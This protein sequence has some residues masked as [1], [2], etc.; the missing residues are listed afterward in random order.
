LTFGSESKT[1]SIIDILSRPTL[2]GANR[3][4]ST[5]RAINTSPTTDDTQSRFKFPF[6]I[7]NTNLNIQN[8]LSGYTHFRANVG[9]KIV[10]NAQPFSQG[11][12]WIYFA[13][14]ETSSMTQTAANNL[15]CKTSYP[16]VELDVATGQP[17]EF[18]IPYC[19]P[20]PFF[21][22]TYGRGTMGD[23]YITVLA[24]ITISDASISIFA[25]FQDIH[26][27]LPTGAPLLLV[28]QSK[29]DDEDE[30]Y[31]KYPVSQSITESEVANS[32]NTNFPVVSKVTSS[33]S[34][35]IE[36]P[37]NW[38]LNAGLSALGLCKP[39][40]TSQPNIIT[41]I[42][43][44]GYTNCDGI[45]SSVVLGASGNSSIGILPGIFS[46]SEDEMDIKYICKKE[47]FLFSKDWTAS[48]DTIASF[49]VN[50]CATNSVTVGTLTGYQ[51][52]LQ[53][54]VGSMFKFW[55]GTMRYRISVAKTAFHSGRLL[56][57]FHPGAVT[58]A[59]TFLDD[60][61]Y[62]WI[63]DLANSSDLSFEIPYVSQYPWSFTNVVQYDTANPSGPTTGSVIGSNN[64]L[65][66][67]GL[68][69]I[70]ALNSLRNAGA[71]SGTVQ[72]LC[73]VSCGDDIEFSDPTF[74]NYRPCL[75]PTAAFRAV[76]TLRDE[77]TDEFV[78]DEEEIIQ[79]DEVQEE[80]E[81]LINFEDELQVIQE[82]IP[83]KYVS[84]A[85]GDLNPALANKTQTNNNF[86]KLFDSPT[87][88]NDAICPGEKITNLRQ[89]I[90]RFAPLISVYPDQVNATAVPGSYGQTSFNN[91]TLDPAYFGGALRAAGSTVNDT[92]SKITGLDNAGVIRTI[93][94]RTDHAIPLFYISHIYRFYRGGL[95][96]K[97][98]IG[99]RGER[100]YTTVDASGNILDNN[101]EF[102]AKG[103]S[104]FYISPTATINGNVNAPNINYESNVTK[105]YLNLIMGSSYQHH[106]DCED[107]NVLEVTVPYY[108]NL[109]FNCI[110]NGTT[111]GVFDSY[112]TRKRVIFQN[113]TP[114]GSPGFIIQTAAADDFNFGYLIGPPC[115]CYVSDNFNNSG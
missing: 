56:I 43:A 72:V 42:P 104:R 75:Q 40:N 114:I 35:L 76:K 57:S 7:F 96:Y 8:K 10:V 47:C 17:V 6:D 95:R 26:L 88:F 36:N 69:R 63:L 12:L 68:V 37:L 60:R 83:V 101:T 24:P 108:S 46:T 50:P 44:K 4:W 48:S 86:I 41:K 22:L 33:I 53:T 1:H 14:Y 52:G 16:G 30:F 49:W 27:E 62:S 45:D 19:S 80:E 20:S 67:P 61:S 23:L 89:L 109:P 31:K 21:G 92:Y 25:W 110:S 55:R 82:N 111:F 99:L 100:Y 2:L 98:F 13:P 32:Q 91:V 78:D 102:M 15:Q 9:I 115:I 74:T 73:W 65:S 51:C 11:K 58:T 70:R 54:Y 66:F 97:S 107:Q 29:N 84:Q 59:V 103:P 112:C 113:L 90:K 93:G 85:F 71:A 77:M 3:I 64:I 34:K 18:I 105:Y 81:P 28:S 106:L 39:P 38:T 94:V 87:K 79:P 5:A